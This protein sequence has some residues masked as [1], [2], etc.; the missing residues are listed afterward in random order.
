M[1]LHIYVTIMTV[2]ITEKAIL[3]L[4]LGA[5]KKYSKSAFRTVQKQGLENGPELC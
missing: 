1:K 5:A 2:R 4:I 3:L